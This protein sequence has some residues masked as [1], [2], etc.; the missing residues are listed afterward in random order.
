MDVD[1]KCAAVEYW[2]RDITNYFYGRPA[3]KRNF[4]YPYW[5]KVS[6]KR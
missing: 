2:V 5:K 1:A 4:N 6:G 3:E